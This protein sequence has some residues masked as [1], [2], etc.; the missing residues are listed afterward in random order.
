M[1]V[2]CPQRKRARLDVGSGVFDKHVAWVCPTTPA[3][4]VSPCGQKRLPGGG[5]RTARDACDGKLAFPAQADMLTTNMCTIQRVHA[6][7]VLDSRGQPTVQVEVFNDDGSWGSAIVPSGASTGKAEAQELRDGDLSRYEGRGVLQAVANVNEIL[8]P[9]VMGLNPGDQSAIDRLLCEIDG[10]PQK[11]KLG[12]NAILGVSLAVAH[13]AAAGTRVPLYRHLHRLWQAVLSG[14]DGDRA[15]DCRMPLPMTNMI[16]GGLHA[17]GNLDFQDFLIMPV[18]APSF[19]VGLEWIVRVYRRLGELLSAAG[20]EG[21]LVGD[22]GGFGP[23]LPSNRAAAEFVVRAIEAAGLRPGDDVTIALD[24]A[25]SHFFD[26]IC[27][28]LKATGDRRLSSGQMIDELEALVESFPVTSIEDGLAEDDWEGWGELTRRLG[29]KVQ[30]IGDDLFATNPD[31]IRRGIAS[32][33]ANAVLIK[34]NQIGTLSETLNAMAIAR[35]AGYRTVVS[36]RSGETED[37]S[38]ADLAVATA[39]DQIKIGS[40]QRSERLAKYNRLLAIEEEIGTA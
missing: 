31:R 6:R 39:A 37:A 2:T 23:R 32:G 28:R 3:I 17:G 11:A 19:H 7:E 38:I 22:E 13:A 15:A 35:S 20:Y 30:L 27:Y 36:A 26:G 12:A 34:L 29:N 4:R 5:A 10:T 33:V 14:F 24:V 25:S 9:A 18:A 16:S 1:T 40:I 8:G 21:R